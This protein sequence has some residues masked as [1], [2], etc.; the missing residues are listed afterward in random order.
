MISVDWADIAALPYDV[1]RFLVASV[2]NVTCG[3]MHKVINHLEMN[4]DDVHLIGHSL[5]A[6]L[7]GNVGNCFK[8]Q[9][10]RYSYILYFKLQATILPHICKALYLKESP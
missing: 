4:L 6:H 10:G 9:L 5:G 2:A 1:A 3:L 8:G 7:A